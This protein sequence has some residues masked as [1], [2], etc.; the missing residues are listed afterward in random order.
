MDTEMNSLGAFLEKL[1]SYRLLRWEVIALLPVLILLRYSVN[2]DYDLWWQMALGKYYLAH[3]TLTVNHSLFSWTP[4]DPG[5]IY[6][7][8]LGSI[9]FYVA[10]EFLGGFGLWIVQ[11]FVLLGIFLSFYLFLRLVRQQ[12]DVTSVTLIAAIGVVIYGP[13]CSYKPELFSV[14][15]FSWTVFIFFC[16]KLTRRT[17]LF[18]LYPLIM[19]L[20][21]NLHGGFILGFVFLALAFLGELLNKFF[22]PRESFSVKDLVHLGAACGL[23]VLATLLNPYGMDYLLGIYNN[24][25]NEVY[26]AVARDNIEAYISLWSFMKSAKLFVSSI[27]Q[28]AWIMVILMFILGGLFL[29]D[30]IKKRFCDFTVLIVSGALFWYGMGTARAS[31]FFPLAFFFSFFY[32]LHR[33]NLKGITARAT[34]LSLF[35]LLFLFISISNSTFRVTADNKWFGAGIDSSVPVK[36]VDFLKKYKIEALIFN[37]YL[38]GGYLIW[39]L[40]P[41]YKVFIDPRFGPY[42]KQVA[43]D[44][45]SFINNPV[46]GATIQHF[47][48]KYPFKIVMIHYNNLSLIAAFLNAGGWRLIFFDQHAAIL[49]HT[50]L[51]PSL[52]P[53][54]LST[55]LSPLRFSQVRNPKVLIR[56]FDFYIYLNPK[57]GRIMYDIYENNV[58]DYYIFKADHLQAMDIKIRHKELKL[59]KLAEKRQMP[60]S[61]N[62]VAPTVGDQQKQ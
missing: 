22:F 55:N 29:Y 53:E 1:A 14:L 30:V 52:P 46:N 42:W 9:V 49:C 15:L 40:Y 2:N 16:V 18:Y 21:V 19:A 62:I 60:A 54:M 59:Q 32:L 17:I 43:P 39:K 6:N 3:H 50:S 10:Y 12:L 7:T 11:W 28:N 35:V 20:W 51:V 58:S 13:S 56:L 44:Y 61:R 27:G 36:E 8:C 25:T 24:A 34:L 45:F 23:S 57:L 31:Y 41:D 26:M 47:T 37:D 33:L 5:W 48:K 38:I 4:T